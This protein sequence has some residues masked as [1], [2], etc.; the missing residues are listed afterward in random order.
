[1]QIHNSLKKKMSINYY[2]NKNIILNNQ[3]FLQLNLIK[4]ITIEMV[5]SCTN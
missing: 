3:S 2:K 4:K 1:M 5:T